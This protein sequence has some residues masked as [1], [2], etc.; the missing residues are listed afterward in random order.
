M[1][2]DQEWDENIAKMMTQ[3]DLLSNHVMGSGSKVVKA[4]RIYRV[5]PNKAQFE[6]MYNEEVKFLANQGGGFRLNYPRL[7][8]NQGWNRNHDDGWRD[9][10]RECRDNGMN[11]REWDGD[12]VRYV[13]PY[14]RQKPK[15]KMAD[16]GKFC[17][18]DMLA[19][20]LNKV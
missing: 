11:W 4:V 1:K 7:G 2:K 3:I 19:R 8:G 18:E 12:K 15:E 10:N 14:D 17:T 20:I 16:P 5:N 13:P 6:A 9:P